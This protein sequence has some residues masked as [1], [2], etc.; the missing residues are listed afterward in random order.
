MHASHSN[1]CVASASDDAVVFLICQIDIYI[2]ICFIIISIYLLYV[3]MFWMNALTD[4]YQP[5]VFCSGLKKRACF[6]WG[7]KPNEDGAL[8]DLDVTNKIG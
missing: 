8:D 5:H 7:F 2:S 4:L 6:Q 3:S 1:G